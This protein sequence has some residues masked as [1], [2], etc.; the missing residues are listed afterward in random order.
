MLTVT[1][2]QIDQWRS[3]LADYPEILRSLNEIEDCEGDVEDAA[4]ALAIHAG[5]EPDNSDRWLFSLAKRY[6]P[7]I[8]ELF[9]QSPEEIVD[10]S[11]IIRHLAGNT[12]CPALLVLPVAVAASENGLEAFC[13]GLG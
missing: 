8:C 7:A 10:T 5:L 13:Q 3:E 1:P 4:V 12:A 9:T 11:S 6:R 2:E